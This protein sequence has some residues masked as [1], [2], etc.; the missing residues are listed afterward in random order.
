MVLPS[1]LFLGIILAINIIMLIMGLVI[2]YPDIPTSEAIVVFLYPWP[3]FV[4]GMN[5]SGI[6]LA[7]WYVFIVSAII[8]SVAWLIRSEG[9]KFIKIINRS[10]RKIRPPPSKS[11]NSFIIIAQLF[12][13]LLFFQ[14]VVMILLLIM[15]IS[16]GSATSGEAPET[17]EPFFYLANASVAEEIFT[18]TLY[19]GLPLLAYDQFIRKRTTKIH[20]YLIGGGFKIENVTIVLIVFSSVLFGFAHYPGWGL[21]KVLPASAAG[22]GF[23]YLFVKK[24]IHTAIILHFLFNYMFMILSFLGGN[25]GIL[26]IVGLLLGL[27][28]LFWFASGLIYFSVYVNIIFENLHKW[29]FGKKNM[30]DHISYQPY[31][32]YKGGK[33]SEREPRSHFKD[34]EKR[35]L[36][37][38]NIQYCPYCRNE[39]I[40]YPSVYRWYCPRCSRYL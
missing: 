6:V 4:Y 10:V 24:G 40:Y 8:L 13:A 16:L 20:R 5:I 34:Y 28:F 19:I 25:L 26:I 1:Y 18:R 38:S 22:L 32:T 3:N 33:G 29:M 39:L 23:G 36:D 37:N 15:G 27:M 9:S 12:F 2:A 31:N 30:G 11:D 7:I 21:W 14:L 17:W 35:I